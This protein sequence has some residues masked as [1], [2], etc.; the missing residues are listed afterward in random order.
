VCCRQ[1]GKKVSSI[2]KHR[3]GRDSRAG[4]TGAAGLIA[5]KVGEEGIPSCRGLG[6]RKLG[7][8]RPRR[9]E[10]DGL[11]RD[12]KDQK[13]RSDPRKSAMAVRGGRKARS[14]MQEK[15]GV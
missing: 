6:G 5:R 13:A 4:G 14:G 3:A 12:G 7:N 9:R 11:L 1:K 10:T 8:G 15:G 2:E